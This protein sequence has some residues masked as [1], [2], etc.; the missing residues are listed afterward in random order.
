MYVWTEDLE[1]SKKQ[2]HTRH[3]YFAL[4]LSIQFNSIP[5]VKKNQ[6]ST[7]WTN[8]SFDGIIHRDVMGLGEI[9]LELW[10][11]KCSWTQIYFQNV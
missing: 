4:H 1:Q 8:M 10:L 9:S 6:M 2:Q 11:Y 5:P 3:A 7:A